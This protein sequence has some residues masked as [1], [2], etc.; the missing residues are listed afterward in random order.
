MLAQGDGSSQ[1]REMS[2]KGISVAFVAACAAFCAGA[3]EITG[4]S[5][6]WAIVVDP[7]ASNGIRDGIKSLGNALS[8][9]LREQL[10]AKVSVH[11]DGRQPADLRHV[12]YI[13]GKFA[14]AAG[15]LDD[16]YRGLDYGIAVKD[17]NVYLYGNDRKGAI[18][19][20]TMGCTVPSAL[21]AARFMRKYMGVLFLMP[22]KIGREV[23][24]RKSLVL[25]DDLRDRGGVL[26]EYQAGRSLDS[27]YDFA[28]NMYGRC[29]FYTYGG[30]TYPAAAPR[31]RYFKT[32]PEYFALQGGKRAWGMSKTCQAYCVS[33][34]EFQELVYRELLNR[35]DEG[36]DCCELG[37]NDGEVRCACENCKALYG[38]GD[39]WS[40]KIWLFHRDLA[41]RVLKD[42]PGKLVQ[43]LSYGV[44]AK[45]PKSFRVFP[46]N[47]LV[48]ICSYS[49]ASMKEWSGYTVPHGFTYYLYNWG[50][51]PIPGFTAKRSL[52]GLVRQVATFNRYGMK[53]TY[54]CG[55]GELF[56]MEG[57]AYYLFH[58]LLEDP[59]ADAR[60]TLGEYCGG[61]FG[62][63][64]G[65]MERFYD[66]LEE[67]LQRIEE[68][69]SVNAEDLVE[70]TITRSA[71]RDPV[72]ALAYIYTPERV[73]KMEGL[74]SA[75]E[76]TDGLSWKA[77][78]RLRLVR[79]EFDYAKNLGQI[80]TVYNDRPLTRKKFDELA[81]LLRWRNEFIEKLYGGMNVV[82]RIGDWPE[83]VPF[84]SPSKEHFRENGRLGAVIRDPLTWDVE[85]MIRYDL[86]PGVQMT[87]DARK[88]EVA[89]KKLRPITG[90]RED[91]DRHRDG[92]VIEVDDS[93][94][95]V[96]ICSPKGNDVR[97]VA[98][99]GKKDG[100]KPGRTYRI[101]WIVRWK[102]IDPGNDFSSAWSGL[103]GCMTWGRNW[104]ENVKLPAGKPHYGTSDWVQESMLVRVADDRD[105][106]ELSFRIYHGKSGEAE[107]RYLTVEEVDAEQNDSPS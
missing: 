43:M 105:N 48:E 61:A 42:R 83:N 40:E 3:V 94:G 95:G 107:V 35:Y 12:I 39:D 92:N 38:T 31:D 88:R 10:G 33:N 54:R 30:H 4:A 41:L 85:K 66:Q 91:K 69:N 36:A 58:R 5:S 84:G 96:K 32:H 34:K 20:L 100:V 29:G 93:C 1:V 37:Q 18:P 104:V 63:S 99:A 102:D 86:L 90:W 6:D 53:G 81:G 16:S 60:A 62:P 73:A 67:P 87:P 59:K 77:V 22:G 19:Y 17:G 2:M 78:K 28:N 52:S 74:L 97:V 57:P 49:E 75:A 64:A 50:W 98:Y 47:T 23:P 9:S 76:R 79:T 65:L 71:S 8:E 25:P 45:P 70:P 106:I 24:V 82:K 89:A 14:R 11:T 68:L 46:A 56:G 44:T 72:A 27:P 21:A 103:C 80:A 13:G 7:G 55:F 101:S 15:L 26:A 51:Y